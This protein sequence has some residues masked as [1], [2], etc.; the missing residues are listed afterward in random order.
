VDI[1][2]KR[3]A[4]VL[5]RRI[6]EFGSENELTGRRSVENTAIAA[7]RFDLPEAITSRIPQR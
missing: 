6:E 5:H 3:R 2:V 7:S 4:F 1:T